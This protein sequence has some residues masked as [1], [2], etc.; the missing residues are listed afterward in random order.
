MHQ[1]EQ[2]IRLIQFNDKTN[3]KL[4]DRSGEN[5]QYRVPNQ[6]SSPLYVNR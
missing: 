6:P 1:M 2:T 3:I 4:N 5:I